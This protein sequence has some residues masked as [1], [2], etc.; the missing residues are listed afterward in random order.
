[1]SIDKFDLDM[2]DNNLVQFAK[3]LDALSGVL[4][5]E[6]IGK[7]AQNMD[8]PA[9]ALKILLARAE[10]VASDATVLET[11]ASDPMVT[12]RARATINGDRDFTLNYD[13]GIEVVA[14]DGRA[15][16]DVDVMADGSLEI[17]VKGCVKHED[18]MLDDEVSILPMGRGRIRVKRL[19]YD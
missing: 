3:A 15:L 18:T 5:E 16:Y 14:H 9:E 10:K 7:A 1:M 8:L 6:T 12:R 19:P 17:S 2:F 11:C 4:S 13:D